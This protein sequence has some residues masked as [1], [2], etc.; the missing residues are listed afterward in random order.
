MTS[1]SKGALYSLCI[2]FGLFLSM[3]WFLVPFAS[4]ISGII[5]SSLGILLI[6]FS[7]VRLYKLARSKQADKP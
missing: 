4:V 5:I 1:K 2:I 3:I 6:I 7:A